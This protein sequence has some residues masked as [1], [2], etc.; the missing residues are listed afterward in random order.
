MISFF[1]FVSTPTLCTSWAEFRH[2]GGLPIMGIFRPKWAVR[3]THHHRA[4]R[5]HHHHTPTP[6]AFSRTNATPS[7]QPR[8]RPALSQAR[9]LPPRP[10]P[11]TAPRAHHKPSKAPH[12]DPSPIA[13]SQTQAT[14][15][16]SAQ[17][18]TPRPYIASHILST[19]SIGF[20]VDSDTGLN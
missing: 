6:T 4:C 3:T 2:F 10:R 1:S 19:S 15:T 16:P 20:C 9:Y 13:L 11:S 17:Y 8:P 5:S 7:P 14:A 12:P 18:A